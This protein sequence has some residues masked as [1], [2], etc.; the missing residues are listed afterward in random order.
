MKVILYE[1]DN[2]YD[3]LKNDMKAMVKE[4]VKE[5]ANEKSSKSQSTNRSE[6]WVG[7]KEAMK[8]LGVKG[9]ATMQKLR[10]HSP[11]NGIKISVNGRIHRYYVP[12]LHEFLQN[13]I[14]R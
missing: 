4:A 12:S 5:L 9:S 6:E 11:M 7:T 8:I 3:L 1:G 14:M 10:D 2:A 13:K